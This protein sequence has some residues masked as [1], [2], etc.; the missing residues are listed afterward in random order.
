[1]HIET[2]LLTSGDERFLWEMLYQAIYVPEG[3]PLP[4][5]DII[6]E[7]GVRCYVES[8]GKPADWGLLALANERP[9]GA[10]WVRLLVGENKGY[11]YIDDQTP[12]LSLAV[13]PDFRGQGIG[14]RLM[15]ELL[16]LAPAHCQAMSLSVTSSNPVRRLYERC[17]FEIVGEASLSLTMVK[18][19]GQDPKRS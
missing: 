15:A 2:R 5:P 7:S 16:H 9:A 11:G 19:W 4:P 8:W 12:E 18:K 1:M 13:L 10:A 6:Y 17:G 14:A 3:D